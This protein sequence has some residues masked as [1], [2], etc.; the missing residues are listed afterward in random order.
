MIDSI[1]FVVDVLSI[2]SRKLRKYSDRSWFEAGTKSS[3]V[4]GAAA[5]T[6]CVR[7]IIV[8]WITPACAAACVCVC[9][10]HIR[11]LDAV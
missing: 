8:D 4:S 9:I 6:R 3:R 1:D 2:V 7:C 5:I 10:E 11:P